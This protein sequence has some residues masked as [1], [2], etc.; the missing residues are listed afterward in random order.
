MSDQARAV[1]AG[2][3]LVLLLLIGLPLLWGGLMMWGMSGSM[4]GPGMMGGWWAGANPWWAI[5][6]VAFWLLMLAGITLLV[7][8]AIRQVG[9]DQAGSRRALEILKERYAR[10]EITREQYE[11]IRRDLE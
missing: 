2:A 4:M 10:G 8:W 9:P 1:V 6:G 3:L 7:V 11:Q 5:L